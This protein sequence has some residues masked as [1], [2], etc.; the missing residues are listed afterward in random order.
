MKEFTVIL[1]SLL[2]TSWALYSSSDDV[3]ELTESNFN[4]EVIQSDQL[5]LVEFY[6]PWCGHC[7]SLAPEWKK[8]ATALK[9][10][11]KVAA[12][13][14][15][16]HQSLGSRYGVQGYPTIKIFGANKNSPQDYQGPRQASGIV[17]S[18]LSSLGSMVRQRLSG[19]KSEGGKSG[20]GGSSGGGHKQGNPEDVV[21]LTDHNFQDLVLDSDDLWMVEFFAPWC[22]HCKNLAPHWAT[23]ATEMK[24]KVKFGAYDATVYKE[25]AGRYGVQ[26]FP[27]IKMFAAGKKSGDAVDYDGGRSSSDIINWVTEKL[28]EN[29][30]PP[31][32]FQI[33]DQDSLNKNCEDRQLCIVAVLPHILDCQSECR[34]RY[35]Q[36]MKDMGEKYKK[37]MWGWLWAEAGA[38]PALED[39]VGVG[40][41]GYPAMVAINSRKM[42][43]STLLGP[44]SD[45]GINEFLRD[46]SYGRGSTAPVKGAKLPKIEKTESWDGKDGQL[47]VDEDIDLSDVDLDD[48]KDEL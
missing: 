7:Q 41:F 43:Y 20:G 35:L 5:W 48:L 31:E 3:I 19:K 9:G 33:V 1:L 14:A 21:E 34:N 12:V 10:V 36:I 29:V 16:A 2:A 24:G 6:A 39:S 22:G 42:M 47:P 30:P 44:F 17:D 28:S 32:L 8:A 11:V 4:R 23:A 15:T 45:K 26:G 25:Y 18:A 38:Q 46:L 13:D 27:T 40:G 37:K